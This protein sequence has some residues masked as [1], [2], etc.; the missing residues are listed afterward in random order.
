MGEEHVIAIAGNP[1]VG[2]STVFNSLTNMHQHTGNWPGKTVANAAGD[3]STEDF[4]YKMVD[5]PGTYSL[6]AHSAEEEAARDFICFGDADAVVIVC[7]ATC[8]ERNLNLV[9]Q[10]MEITGRVIVCVNL[11]DEAKKKGIHVSLEELSKELGVPVIGMV[12]REGKG[13]E[14]LLDTLDNMMRKLQKQDGMIS[15]AYDKSSICRITYSE[16][17]E[18]AVAMLL[19][20]VNKVLDNMPAAEGKEC[21]YKKNRINPRWLSVKL[22][23]YDKTLDEG[24]RTYLHRDICMEPE[25]ADILPKAKRILEE[26]GMDKK[27]LEEEIVSSVMAIAEKITEK[28]VVFDSERADLQDRKIDRILTGRRLGYPIMAILLMLILWLTIVGANY[29]SQLL[30]AAL[31]KVQDELTAFF[32]YIGAPS[33]LHGMLVLGVYRVVAWVVSVMLPP[34]A[35]FFPMFTLLEDVGYLPRIAYNLD[36]PFKKCCACGKQALT[37]CMGCVNLQILF[38]SNFNILIL[39]Y[40]LIY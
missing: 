34:M 1:N 7:D 39:N 12:A 25:I 40:N 17:L 23:D 33:W 27:K 15:D 21:L 14:N 29:P 9:L 8:L 35:L 38:Q 11:L 30:S 37:L 5:I 24:V 4:T 32:Q 28:S 26:A 31:F 19:P 6:L 36:K 20:A 3:C 13:L 16:P 18:S 22:L 10:T 2:K